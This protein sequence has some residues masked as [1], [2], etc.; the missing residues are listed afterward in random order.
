MGAQRGMLIKVLKK[1]GGGGKHFELG[2]DGSSG[3]NGDQ[4][5]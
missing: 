4:D 2:D 1:V 5:L 3:G